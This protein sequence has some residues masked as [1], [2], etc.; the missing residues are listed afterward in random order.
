MESLKIF[1]PIFIKNLINIALK[2]KI[3]LKGNYT[4]WKDAKK[5]SSGY[6]D[7]N[8]FLKA[9]SS[10]IKILSKEAKFERD[11]VL[12]YKN[13]PDKEMVLII[14]KM[15][16]NKKLKICDFGGSFG[17]SYFQNII[18]LD[19]NKI[20]WNIVEQK[21]IVEY[22]NKKIKIKN[23]KFSESLRDVLKKKIDLVILSSVIQYLEDPYKILKI[24][25]K[26]KVKKIYISRTPFYNKKD[27]IKIQYVPKHIYK[28]SYPVRIF[29]RSKIIK[30]MKLNGYQVEK[31][32]V[33][34]EKLD[35]FVYSNFLFKR[36]Y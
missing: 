33:I 36:S 7:P 26:S 23:L 8:I 25:S 22:A 9:K 27:I 13:S 19:K 14:K 30:F 17:S 12:F 32:K 5:I 20:E 10:L 6:D 28:S 34:N 1:L 4:S 21:K 24:I 18:D 2:R 29:N 16:K 3:I 35:Q 15:Y 31:K 11:T